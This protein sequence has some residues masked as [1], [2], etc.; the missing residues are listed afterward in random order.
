MISVLVRPVARRIS[1]APEALP[2][3][4]IVLSCWREHEVALVRAVV[5]ATIHRAPARVP[6]IGRDACGDGVPHPRRPLRRGPRG[7]F[8]GRDLL[9]GLVLAGWEVPGVVVSHVQLLVVCAVLDVLLVAEELHGRLLEAF[10]R[11]RGIPWAQ[12]ILVP[13]SVIGD[14]RPLG[15]HHVARLPDCLCGMLRK[16][17]SVK[18]LFEA[19]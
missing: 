6:G 5:L 3:P 1:V 16:V 11:L 15:L 10:L 14:Q 12:A 17:N 7:Y 9:A 18:V 8:V 2:G 19:W 4:G 13:A